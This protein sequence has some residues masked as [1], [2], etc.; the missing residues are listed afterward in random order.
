MELEFT[1]NALKRIV[2]MACDRS[3]GARGLRSIVESVLRKCMFEMPSNPSINQVIVDRDDVDGANELIVK[4]ILK[5][6]SE[7]ESSTNA[8]TV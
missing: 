6:P 8:V 3:V 5:D 7:L 2:E 1:D 4:E